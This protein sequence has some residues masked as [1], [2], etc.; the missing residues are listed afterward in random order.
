[1]V[2]A[3][4]LCAPDYRGPFALVAPGEFREAM[5]ELASGVALVTSAFER[6]RAGC[7]VSSFASLSL[8]PASLV[9]CLNAES[10]TLACIRASG[11]F[12]VNILSGEQEAL[13]RRFGSP[14]LR[15]AERFAQGE[16]GA[17]ATGAPTLAGAL[18]VVDCRLARVVE[19]ATHAMV[20]GEAV[21][22][23]RGTAPSALVHWRSQF[24]A[25]R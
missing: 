14:Q 5:R 19:H 11:V 16:W 9:V 13:A 24:E 4:A 10:S 20:I 17:T 18:A 2:Y 7:A 23:A 1:M 3:E 12:A 15:G 8:S 22:V 6:T 25:L 21:A